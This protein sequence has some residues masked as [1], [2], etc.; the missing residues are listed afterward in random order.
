[1]INIVDDEVED[2]TKLFTETQFLVQK[3][4]TVKISI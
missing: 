1:M 4:R 2:Q 3:L